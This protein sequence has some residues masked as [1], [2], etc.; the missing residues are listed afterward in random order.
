MSAPAP[1]VPPP[2][3]GQP[4]AA[5]SPAQFSF[6]GYVST[7]GGLEGV[8]FWPRVGGRL[9]DLVIHY[10]SNI[11]GGLVFGL[12]LGVVG[13]MLGKSVPAMVYKIQHLGFAAFGL[14]LLGQVAYH[15]VCESVHGSTA[16]KMLLSMVVVQEDGT[17]C[18]FDSALLRSFSYFVD[19]LFFGLVGYLAMQKTSQNQ[20]YGDQWAH[21]IVCR[22]SQV[23]P[24][25]LRDGSRF[26]IALCLGMA[27]D[28][29]M[30]MVGWTVAITLM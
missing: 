18:K 19:A 7:P 28:A 5:S 11:V 23:R 20:R 16:G 1:G 21:T 22:R 24:E 6:G 25:N 9:I 17:P 2:P 12:V 26:A 10:I 30:L 14:A 8:G 27:A 29:L 4:P 13:T 15:T 3:G